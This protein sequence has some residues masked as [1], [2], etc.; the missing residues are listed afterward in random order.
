[1]LHFIISGQGEIAAVDVQGTTEKLVIV[2]KLEEGN[3]WGLPGYIAQSQ[4]HLHYINQEFDARLSIWVLED[5]DAKKWVLKHRVKLF[6]KRRPM[7]CKNGYHVVA[8]HP[9]GNV[10]FI[11]QSWNLKLISYD[12]DH[13]LVRVIGTVKDESCVEHVMPYVPHFFESS[14]LRNKH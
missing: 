8:M 1:M 13:K 4:G 14:V 10:I 2:P 12:M 3:C 11:V 7:G 6:G 5:Y 9:D